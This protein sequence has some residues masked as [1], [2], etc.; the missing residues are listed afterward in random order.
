MKELWVPL[1]GAIA[2]QRK[3]DT[4]ANNVANANTPGFKKDQLTFREYITTLEKGYDNI[5]MPNK[6][7]APA[8]FYRSYGAE[9]AQVKVDASYTNFEQGQLAPTG[10]SLDLGLR[11]EGFLEI[12]TPNGVRFSRRGIMSLN[13]DGLLVNDSGFPVLSKP[14]TTGTDPQSRTIKIPPAT[15]SVA[16]TLQG[17]IFAD[18][19]N[20]A[21]LNVSEFKDIN[22]LRKEGNSLFINKDPNNIKQE[23]ATS[24]HQGFVEQSNVNSIQ[25]MSDL[26]KAHRQFES[27]QNV[28]K[29]YDQV[30][31]KGVNEIS[32]F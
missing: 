24:V 4:I 8:D 32:K 3:V 18:N 7:W 21:K 6:E 10:N 9:H 1:S 2:Q 29:A 27:I 15:K 22:A 28:I 23:V 19:E 13:N 31:Q 16:I 12:L 25:E 17:D 5:D 30:S 26:I 14:S 11:G 20:I